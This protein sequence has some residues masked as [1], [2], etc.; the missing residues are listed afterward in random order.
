MFATT[1]PSRGA[2]GVSAFIVEKGTPGF[3]FG[4]KEHKMGIR[5]NPTL[6]TRLPKLPHPQEEPPL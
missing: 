4:K 3:G 6:R 2:R 1:N 5:A